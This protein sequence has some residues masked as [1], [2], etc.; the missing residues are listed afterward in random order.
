MGIKLPKNQNQ[1]NYAEEFSDNASEEYGGADKEESLGEDSEGNGETGFDNNFHKN[2]T[3]ANFKRPMV[4]ESEE[5]ESEGV[6]DDDGES[7]GEDLNIAGTSADNEVKSQKKMSLYL[8]E[9]AKKK[10]SAGNKDEKVVVVRK[11]TQRK[12]KGKTRLTAYMVWAK[13]KRPMIAQKNPQL[14]FSAVTK[15][16]GEMWADVSQAERLVWKRRAMRLARKAPGGMITTGVKAIKVKAEPIKAKVETPSRAIKRTSMSPKRS[17]IRSP[18]NSVSP[19]K[20]RSKILSP[21]G[22]EDFTSSSELYNNSLLLSSTQPVA[23]AGEMEPLD[24]ASHLHL[25]GESLSV[26]GTRLKEHEVIIPVF[27][28]INSAQIDIPQK[29]CVLNRARTF[30]LLTM[31]KYGLKNML[32]C[33]K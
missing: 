8:L 6:L 22:F 27:F 26:I 17:P 2:Q 20:Q 12:D 16:L 32:L 5:E 19:S 28:L 7:E 3:G 18:R 10:N 4:S 1:N 33:S 13:E 24:V 29:I 30:M 9:N 23:R 11:K 31:A 25:L 21:D 15:R 14:D